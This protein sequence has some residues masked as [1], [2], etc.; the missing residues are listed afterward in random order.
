M[1]TLFFMVKSKNFLSVLIL[2]L[3]LAAFA[4]D[5][6]KVGKSKAF[7]ISGGISL[8]NIYNSANAQNPFSYYLGA[9]LNFD[10][11][12]WSVPLSF[13]YSNREHSFTQPFNQYGL[14]PTYK[15]ITMHLGYR[16]LN[17][18]NYSYAGILF[19]GA[20]IEL[21]PDIGL[22]FTGFYGQLQK[23]IQPDTLNQ[24]EISF[25]RLGCGAKLEYSFSGHSVNVSLFKAYDNFNSL[26]YIPQNSNVTPHE[27]LVFTVG[28]AS[29]PI[30]GLNIN[31]EWASSAFT[32]DIRS[33]SVEETKSW[34]RHAGK[35]LTNRESSGYYWAGRMGLNYTFL[36]SIAGLNYEII[37]PG[38]RT[39][40]QYYTNNDIETLSLNFGQSVF[41]DKVNLTVS[42]GQERN[43]LNNNEVEETSRLVFASGININFSQKVQGNGSFSTFQSYTR[44]R[45]LFD[46]LNVVPGEPVDSLNFTQVNK[47]ANLSASW[48]ISKSENKQ[49][50]LNA[51]FN[52][53]GGVNKGSED[54]PNSLGFTES[55]SY[56]VNWVEKE[57]TLSL[58]LNSNQNSFGELKTVLLGPTASLGKIFFGKKLRSMITMAYNTSV[59]GGHSASS[60]FF[61]RIT[62]QI[63]LKKKHNINSMF[64]YN[65]RSNAM[66]HKNGDISL[67]A[68]YSFS[69]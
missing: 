27:N 49:Q 47:S 5:L 46:E 33:E 40:G 8:N 14:S 58:S 20:G 10:F 59:S 29:T 44:V 42:A 28:G 69:F 53:Q 24:T 34:W 36:K 25:Q 17:F 54:A 16:S 18:S 61:A 6:S 3:P 32:E 1:L 35:L 55:I 12:G 62:N 11:Y 15:W 23:A 48:T 56:R 60:T 7:R 57:S 52:Y 22:K 13:S 21:S 50:N 68:G 9:N 37:N 19:K 41:K 31:F 30:K 64:G 39:L 4:Q 2:F 51:I 26:E 43:N 67:S 66:N 65:V 45:P 38:Y 63:S